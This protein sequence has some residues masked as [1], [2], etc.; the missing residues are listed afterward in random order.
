MTIEREQGIRELAG[1]L[2]VYRCH[3]TH[4]AIAVARWREGPRGGATADTIARMSVGSKHVSREDINAYAHQFA[5]AP[6]LLEALKEALRIH[7]DG[8]SWGPSARAAIALA[9]SD[10][11]ETNS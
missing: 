2:Y 3:E 9:S 5:A 1:K 7:G 6:A 8:Y 10:G 11:K 4:D